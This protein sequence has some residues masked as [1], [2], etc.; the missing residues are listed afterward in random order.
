MR[1]TVDAKAFVQALERV[2]GLIRRSTI[3][4][5]NAVLVRF[6]EDRCTLTSTNIETYLSAAL[7][8]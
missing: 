1:A 3:P 8:A 6:E 4:A 2:S 5:L 7:P